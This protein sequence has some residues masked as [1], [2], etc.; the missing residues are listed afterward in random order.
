MSAG[1]VQRCSRTL[2]KPRDV[3]AG[4]FADMDAGHLTMP[5]CQ[6]QMMKRVTPL[7]EIMRSVDN[8][9]SN[10]ATGLQ[11][12][13]ALAE[14]KVLMNQTCMIVPLRSRH[15]VLFTGQPDRTSLPAATSEFTTRALSSLHTF[16][17]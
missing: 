8:S 3:G 1:I 6:V 9:W 12:I 17:T 10:I 4:R 14:S 13:E 16:Q 7:E 2:E 11:F 5:I 15:S